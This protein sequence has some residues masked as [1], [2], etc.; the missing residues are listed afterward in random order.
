MMAAQTRNALSAELLQAIRGARADRILEEEDEPEIAVGP[1]DSISV[2][3]SGRSLSAVPPV[4][5]AATAPVEPDI[6]IG[7]LDFEGT[8]PSEGDVYDEES[9]R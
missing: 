3:F 4:P 1:C 7:P 2:R 6:A 5:V 8:A 9:R